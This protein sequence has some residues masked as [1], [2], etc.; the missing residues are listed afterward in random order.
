AFM[1]E[2]E[3]WEATHARMD[4]LDKE[5]IPKLLPAL[6]EISNRL[7]LEY[8]GLDCTIRPNGDLLIFEANANMNILFNPF[9]E[10]NDR[11][12][13]IQTRMH[14]MLEKYSGEQVI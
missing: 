4:L 12:N 10:M 8:F 6:Q 1:R 14:A 13:K 5:Q 3:S 11:L 2:R 7:Q 9:P